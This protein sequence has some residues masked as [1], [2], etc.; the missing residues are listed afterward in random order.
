MNDIQ[1]IPN[2]KN[3]TYSLIHFAS[4]IPYNTLLSSR[5]LARKCK[6]FPRDYLTNF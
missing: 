6:T 1:V 4:E 3:I 2:Y 5:H